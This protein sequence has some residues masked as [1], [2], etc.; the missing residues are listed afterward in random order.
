MATIFIPKGRKTFYISYREKGKNVRRNTYFTKDELHKALALK[1]EL[2]E[3]LQEIN[4]KPITKISDSDQNKL[5]ISDAINDFII[6]YKINWSKGRYNNVITTLRIFSDHI[7]EVKFV[8]DIN[9]NNISEFIASRRDKVSITTVRSDINVLRTFFNYL[10]EENLI[11]KSPINRKL[12]PKPEHKGIITFDLQSINLIMERLKANDSLFY[13]YLFILSATGARPG[14]ILRL[15]YGNIDLN[16]DTIRI[17]IQK[18]AREIIFPMY[19]VLRNF[20]IEELPEINFTDPNEIIF[21]EYNIPRVGKKFRKIK[22]KLALNK[23]FNLKTFRKTFATRLAEE[24]IDGLVV[25]YL[26]GHTSVNTTTKYYINKK[27]R[28]IKNNLNSIN[29]LE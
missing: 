23:S 26:L 8:S 17:K 15:T 2:E 29:F 3:K 5:K 14:D 28:V 21:K 7:K 18:T 27:T 16:N 25:A 9:S 10:F 12:I 4:K 11:N 24:G 22:N 13:K 1:K 20:I 6:Y 19:N